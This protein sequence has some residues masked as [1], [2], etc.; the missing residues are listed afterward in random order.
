MGCFGFFDDETD[1][2]RNGFQ[3][4]YENAVVKITFHKDE[5]D[6]GVLFS[7]NKQFGSSLFEWVIESIHSDPDM[8]LA[9]SP[10]A[11]A[12]DNVGLILLFYKAMTKLPYDVL[13][14]ECKSID[15]I[16]PSNFPESLRLIA[17]GLVPLLNVLEYSKLSD[18]KFRLNAIQQTRILFSKPGKDEIPA[19][20]TQ[21]EAIDKALL[22]CIKV[23]TKVYESKSN[24]PKNYF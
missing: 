12:S 3:E 22:S 10:G 1:N 7:K 23:E 15:D 18:F 13:A 17:S 20:A 11:R 2:V 9:D 4:W 16:L 19:T 6:C 8:W 5:F 14:G 21:K 24:Q